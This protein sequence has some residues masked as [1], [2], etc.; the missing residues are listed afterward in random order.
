M[1][2]IPALVLTYDRNRLATENMILQYEALLGPDFFHFFVPFQ[3]NDRIGPRIASRVTLLESDPAIPAT[4]ATLT[5]A[6][7]PGEMVYWCIDDKY[8]VDLDVA[9]YRAAGALAAQPQGA[10][11]GI[12]GISLALARRLARGRG[13]SP[14]RTLVPGLPGALH[15]RRNFNQF[16]LHQ[17]MKPEC[18]DFV[19]SHFPRSL[20]R[21]KEMDAH[22]D[23]ITGNPFAMYVAGKNGIAFGESTSRGTAT[24]NLRQALQR[25]G[26]LKDAAP[27]PFDFSDEE[28][29]IGAL[30]TRIRSRRFSL[31]R[32]LSPPRRLAA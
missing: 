13:L 28:I 11:H 23:R 25:N 5:G 14:R 15:R 10:R 6:V 29:W 31:L 4:V 18:I 8:P 26:L 7:K 30:G 24:A 27:P 1:P 19:F 2:P 17:F 3:K 12:D 9:A 20:R 32:S 22:L 16:W 21:A